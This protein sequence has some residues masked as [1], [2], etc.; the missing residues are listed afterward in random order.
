MTLQNAKSIQFC[1]IVIYL[2]YG[3]TE[4]PWQCP[5]CPHYTFA[6]G[7]WK[8]QMYLKECHHVSSLIVMLPKS[9]GVLRTLFNCLKV[10]NHSIAQVHLHFLSFWYLCTA[11]QD[12]YKLEQVQM[13][14]FPSSHHYSAW[15]RPWGAESLLQ[16]LVVSHAPLGP[17]IASKNDMPFPHIITAFHKRLADLL[18]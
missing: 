1:K 3:S 7:L 15:V 4:M 18:K 10:T 6:V 9:Q 13:H 17:V 11:T 2:W 14:H 16:L 8:K 12:W 5:R